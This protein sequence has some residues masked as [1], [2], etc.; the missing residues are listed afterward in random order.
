MVA[1]LPSLSSGRRR[2]RVTDRGPVPKRTLLLAIAG[3]TFVLDRLTKLAV[4]FS[5]PPWQST[6]IVPD[7]LHLTHVSNAG[8]ALGFRS[9]ERWLVIGLSVGSIALLV[10]LYRF[11]PRHL[12]LRLVAV[13]LAIGGACGNLFDRVVLP[14]G[15]IDFVQLRV[16]GVDWPI[17]NLADV[18]VVLGAVG[19]ALSIW[20]DERVVY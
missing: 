11:L 9:G 1:T 4:A 20:W 16:A 12:S 2:T 6:P 18:A 5:I 17:F 3:A 7:I 8:M 13:A 10:L 14:T 19:L 15:V